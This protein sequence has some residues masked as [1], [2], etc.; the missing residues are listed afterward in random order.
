VS[1]EPVHALV[2]IGRVDGQP[3]RLEIPFQEAF[4]FQ[5]AADALADLP[6]A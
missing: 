5:I 2:F 3:G 1:E 6:Y 4:A